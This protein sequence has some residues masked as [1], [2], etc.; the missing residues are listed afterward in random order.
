MLAKEPR[1]LIKI[2]AS[3][4]DLWFEGKEAQNIFRAFKTLIVLHILTKRGEKEKYPEGLK[5]ISF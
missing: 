2:Y 4:S 3:Y 1:P 5:K